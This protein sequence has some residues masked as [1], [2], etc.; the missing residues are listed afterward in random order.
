MF[1]GNHPTRVDEKGRLK[2][3]AEFKREVDEKYGSQF[4]I[5]SVDGERAQV[6]PMP[7]WQKQ[8]EKLAAMPNSLPAKKKLLDRISYYGQVAEMDPQGRVLV[9]QVLRESA[10]VAGDVVVFGK[11]T[12][13]EV[14]N[15]DIFK[16]KLDAE[17][18]TAEDEAAL[19]SF[20]L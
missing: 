11:M 5:T 1:R 20:G 14:A 7:E 3:P 6:W 4:F 12:F 13:L 9:P 18:I 16:A 2:I 19:A 10:K 17:P 15:H 8:E